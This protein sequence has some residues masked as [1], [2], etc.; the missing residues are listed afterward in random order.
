MNNNQ[1]EPYLGDIL[2][3]SK[4]DLPIKQ[5]IRPKTAPKISYNSCKKYKKK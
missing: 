1:F 2:H 3:F 5:R 4:L